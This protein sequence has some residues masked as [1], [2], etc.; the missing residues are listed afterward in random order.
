MSNNNQER[1]A[2][3][4]EQLEAD[5]R[6]QISVTLDGHRILIKTAI[7]RQNS[8]RWS[9]LKDVLWSWASRAA[10]ADYTFTY[11]LAQE[12]VRLRSL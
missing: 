3:L 9:G 8:W 11:R 2:T 1:T 6:A 5:I 10:T 12:A 4:T 7:K